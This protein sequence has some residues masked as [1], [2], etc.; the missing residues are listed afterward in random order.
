MDRPAMRLKK[1]IGELVIEFRLKRES[2][3]ESTAIPSQ[4]LIKVAGEI[5]GVVWWWFVQEITAMQLITISYMAERVVGTGSFGIVF[6]AKCLENGETVAIKKVLQ[7]RRYKNRVCHRDVKPQNVLVDPLTHQVK[8]RDFGS[9]KV[10]LRS[11]AGRG[12]VLNKG[13]QKPAME[14]NV[15]KGAQLLK[16][17]ATQMLRLCGLPRPEASE[18]A[19]EE[20]V[21]DEWFYIQ[22]VKTFILY[23]C[24]CVSL[25]R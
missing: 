24:S 6:Q 1:N 19:D 5:G 20:E 4:F 12:V 18:R 2:V 13:M 25:V 11:M 8:I 17:S 22:L 21:W 23:L 16:E 14:G 9:A 7:D 10:L 15:K 3:A